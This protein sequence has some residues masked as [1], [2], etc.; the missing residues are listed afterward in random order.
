MI[1]R[2]LC[3][4]G[5]RPGIV[6]KDVK[7]GIFVDKLFQEVSV[8]KAKNRAIGIY[9]SN[10]VVLSA[11]SSQG[12]YPLVWLRES[13]DEDGNT[14]WTRLLPFFGSG[15]VYI[16]LVRL[17]HI[18]E[19]IDCGK[20]GVDLV[21]SVENSDKILSNTKYSTTKKIL[22]IDLERYFIDGLDS[23]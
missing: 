15:L 1:F 22:P 6:S 18:E 8:S 5:D 11:I 4:V 9:E 14:F 13:V 16:H 3:G 20:L 12:G 2:L 10:P 21:L 19:A 7:S 17:S 23:V